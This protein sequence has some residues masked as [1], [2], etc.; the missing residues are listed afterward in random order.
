MEQ[1]T[2]AARRTAALFAAADEEDY[3]DSDDTGVLPGDEVKTLKAKLKE[4]RGRS[5]W[6]G[7][8]QASVIRRHCSSRSTRLMR[9]LQGTR[10][11]KTR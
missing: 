10:R 6:P 2:R 7:A 3:E 11:S 9:D 4:L 1:Q 5:G 8:I